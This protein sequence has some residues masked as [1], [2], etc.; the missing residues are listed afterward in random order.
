MLLVAAQIQAAGIDG[1][2]GMCLTTEQ[3]CLIVKLVAPSISLNKTECLN[4]EENS[5][6]NIDFLPF[7]FSL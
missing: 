7:F 6:H 4:Q 3:T 2:A 1:S 5:C